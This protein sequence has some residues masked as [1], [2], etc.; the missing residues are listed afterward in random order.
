MLTI[1]QTENPLGR[2]DYCLL[3]QFETQDVVWCL[4]QGHQG[5]PAL[6]CQL[7]QYDMWSYPGKAKAKAKGPSTSGKSNSV[8]WVKAWGRS[9]CILSL[10]VMDGNWIKTSDSGPCKKNP[11]FP[12]MS[13]HGVPIEVSSRASY[14]V[15]LQQPQCWTE[16]EVCGAWKRQRPLCPPFPSA[17]I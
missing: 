16:M 12:P 8:S 11:S 1:H 7:R 6:Y 17:G 14:T 15:S 5:F 10:S 9:F 4:T 2:I 3:E 13:C